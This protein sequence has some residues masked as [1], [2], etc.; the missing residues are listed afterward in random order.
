[1]IPQNDDQLMWGAALMLLRRHGEQ[2]PLKVAERIG[3][4]AL[5]GDT[6][7]VAVWTGIAS[8]LDKLVKV[9][10]AHDGAPDDWLEEDLQAN[11][12]GCRAQPIIIRLAF[13]PAAVV[14]IDVETSSSN[15]SH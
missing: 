11:L 13:P 3:A 10:A 14:L 1:M 9:K 5:E 15:H 2:A 8:R 12:L 7:G 4:L 6:L